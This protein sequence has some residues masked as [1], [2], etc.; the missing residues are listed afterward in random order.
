MESIYNRVKTATGWKFER[1]EEGQGKRTAHL[2]PPFYARPWKDGKQRWYRLHAETFVQAK[3]EA[4]KLDAALTADAMGL[5][6]AEAES[7]GNRTP[8]AVAVRRF[9]EDNA[10]KAPKTVAQYQHALKQ[11][12]ESTRV[13]FIDEVTVDAL[14]RFKADL[15]AEGYAGK[16]IDTRVNIV[17]FM[18]KD[19][20]NDAR[21]P[22]K[23]MPTVEEEAAVPYSEDELAKLFAAMNPEDRIRYRF[24]L[25][26]GCRDR[27]VTFAAWN[28]IDFDAH[29]YH[30]RKKP[31]VGFFPKTHE[32]RTIEL[33]APLIRE[34][35]ERC[36]KHPN[37]RFVF[38]SKQGKPDNHFL[39]KLKKI[40]LRAGLNCGHCKTT[41]TVGEYDGKKRVEVSCKTHPVCEHY[42]LH[43]FRK[44][45]ATRWLQNGATLLDIQ[46]L[47][48]HKS[49]ATTQ[50]YLGVSV[51]AK[52]RPIIDRAFGD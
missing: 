29:R 39:R 8:L 1:V 20:K 48:G 44:T 30:V 43:R 51:S 18:L 23:Y 37:D 34:L 3:K 36:E 35:K 50:K 13:K 32:S 33:P 19:N 9:M 38:L 10:S 49:L 25:G 5:T 26:S 21:I 31:D 40:A 17:Y 11:F 27:E 6:V 47:L 41:I 22:T 45:C 14:K 16:T 2:T 7:I 24:F 46:V 52:L 12:S 15:E 4:E 42:I 28:D